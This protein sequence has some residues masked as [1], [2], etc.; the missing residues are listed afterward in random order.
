MRIMIIRHKKW[1]QFTRFRILLVF[2]NRNVCATQKLKPKRKNCCGNPCAAEIDKFPLQERSNQESSVS[3]NGI[4]TC[5]HCPRGNCKTIPPSRCV[6]YPTASLTKVHRR[7]QATCNWLGKISFSPLQNIFN[8]SSWASISL[9][10]KQVP[11]PFFSADIHC[12]KSSYIQKVVVQLC[13]I[14][15]GY[16]SHT[17]VSLNNMRLFAY[18]LGYICNKK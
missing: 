15:R 8:D 5:N 7:M 16:P 2:S 3:I 1:C 18:S 11:K 6:K 9:R 14:T 13:S 12:N 17:A 4:L 10:Q